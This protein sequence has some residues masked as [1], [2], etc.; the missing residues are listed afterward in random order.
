MPTTSSA[1]IGIDASRAVS[2]A[3]TGTEAYSAHL[4]RALA[5][6][7]A[8]THTL[9]LYCRE[10]PPFALDTRG[11]GP[12]SAG[13]E[14]AVETRVIPFPRLWTHLRLSW[15]MVRHPPDL[16]FV[17]AH[18]L[19]VVRPRR[20]LVTVHDLGFRRFPEAHPTSQRQYLEM[21]TR[22]NARVATHIL[23][24]SEAT[25][26]AIIEAY[27]VPAQKLTVVYPGYEPDLKPVRDHD[28]LE[29]VRR[30]Y[31]IPGDYVLFVGRIQPRKNLTRL[32]EAFSRVLADHPNL[33]LVLAGPA[34]WLANP[35]QARATALGVENKVIFPGYVAP[36]DK[37]ALIS[38]AR[39][40]AYPSLYEGF[41]FPVLEAQACGTPL[42]TST[43][44]SLPEVAG[45]GGLL[46]DPLNVE[47]IADGL[48]RLLNNE[49]LSAQ[50]VAR[51]FENLARF[52][53]D[54][55]ARQVQ[56]VITDLLRR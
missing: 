45:K 20:T 14:A 40:F 42:L 52:S 37:A 11:S 36:E 19:P 31:N 24:D 26:D 6:R 38:G 33:M 28:E 5:P 56:A 32:I 9:R 46:V 55:A 27:D 18:V 3:P 21:S 17:P 51:G 30:R 8:S 50:L 54:V 22:W 43:T 48:R 49:A 12:Q 35:I 10:T 7:L 47:A 39:L 53:W 34:G 44:S 29:R 13:S 16:L 15:E 1:I 25:R 2:A 41:G 4:I 23:A